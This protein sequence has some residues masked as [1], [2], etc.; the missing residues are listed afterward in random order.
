MKKIEPLQGLR[1]ILFLTI[2]IYH[3]AIFDVIYESTIHKLF[4]RGGA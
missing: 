2:F 1:M 3:A 4:F